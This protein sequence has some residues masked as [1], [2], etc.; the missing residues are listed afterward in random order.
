MAEL[1]IKET[2]N[3]FNLVSE[4]NKKLGDAV[5]LWLKKG[6][7]DECI[8]RVAPCRMKTESSEYISTSGR[9]K[10]NWERILRFRPDDFNLEDVKI[11]KELFR[12]RIAL[13]MSVFISFHTKEKEY[14][15]KSC[16][17]R[18]QTIN[19]YI[20]EDY[21]CKIRGKITNLNDAHVMELLAGKAV[22]FP[23]EEK[24]IFLQKATDMLVDF[25]MEHAKPGTTEVVKATEVYCR[26]RFN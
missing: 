23:N 13:N 16:H 9:T 26:E 22:D 19:A 6:P 11:N 7:N 17:F 24:P 3:I 8:L 10:Q 25:L 4:E 18:I 1:L 15:E 21:M 14:G 20:P 2:E 5:C 12:M